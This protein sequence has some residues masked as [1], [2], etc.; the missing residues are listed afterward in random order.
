MKEIDI[1]NKRFSQWLVLKRDITEIETTGSNTLSKW[2]CKCDCGEVKSVL[3]RSLITER[4]KSCGGTYHHLGKKNKFWRGYG[5]LNLSDFARI[6][7]DAIRRKLEFS[8]TIE[9]V[10]ELF[11]QQHGLC[12]LSGTEISVISI[13]YKKTASLDRIDPKK[14]YIVGNVQWVHKDVNFMKH[15]FNEEKFIEWCKLIDEFNK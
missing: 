4:S 2:I 6:K 10:W 8:L 14:G 7:K 1:T 3:Y 13:K 15:V 5:D 12:A 11:R 9:Y